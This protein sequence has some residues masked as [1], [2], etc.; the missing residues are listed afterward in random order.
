MKLNSNIILRW[1]RTLSDSIRTTYTSPKVNGI[2]PHSFFTVL[3]ALST[4]LFLF[5][6]KSMTFQN[7][8]LIVFGIAYQTVC[9]LMI[10]GLYIYAFY[11]WKVYLNLRREN[12]IKDNNLFFSESAGLYR[13]TLFYFALA[14]QYI[15]E[16]RSHPDFGEIRYQL[17]V[18][19]YREA[20]ITILESAIFSILIIE[21]SRILFPKTFSWSNKTHY[22][23]VIITAIAMSGLRVAALNFASGHG[24]I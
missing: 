7:K 18:D 22:A 14:S 17:R 8:Y 21:L 9:I 13:K 5:M 20:G 12:I 6:M 15:L 23:V 3:A 19:F 16:L 1:H 24:I 4:D 2:K 10:S 11:C